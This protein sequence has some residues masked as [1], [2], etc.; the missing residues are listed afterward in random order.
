MKRRKV[1]DMEEARRR[2]QPELTALRDELRAV[3]IDAGQRAAK[4][5]AAMMARGPNAARHILQPLILAG[6]RAAGRVWKEN[7]DG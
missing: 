1:V 5:L 6:E 2:L 3:R 4:A 7:D